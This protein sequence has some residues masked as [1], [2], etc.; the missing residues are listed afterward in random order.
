MEKVLNDLF[1]YANLKIY[2]YDKAF[3]FSLDSILLAEYVNITAKTQK[4]LDLCTGN[5]AVPLIL[6]T[7]TNAQIDAFEIQKEIYLL[8]EESLKINNLENNIKIYNDSV[9]N[10][11]TYLK[12]QKYDIITCNPPYFKV[13]ENSN[14]N[15]N[16]YAAIARHELTVTLENIFEI[17]SN[18]LNTGGEF[19]LVH[20]VNRLDEI[21][22]YG[23]KYKLRVKNAELITTTRD[24][25][26]YIVL[27]RCV[28][29]SKNG[30][31]INNPKCIFNRK[32]YQN[33]F[34]EEI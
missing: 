3:K 4:I 25:M 34:R 6:S 17:A 16:S 23:E 18:H 12:G 20:R 22:I 14:I 33:M 31:K 24:S 1:D 27:V 8:A 21:I 30:I 11:D 28:K 5:A 2:Q 9:L 26:P 19:Y 15:N 10:I 13:E 7:K 32:T 29:D